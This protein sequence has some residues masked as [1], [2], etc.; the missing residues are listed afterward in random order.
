MAK[1][2][3]LDGVDDDLA[4]PSITIDYMEME[5]FIPEQPPPVSGPLPILTINYGV[6]M[7]YGLYYNQGNPVGT[8]FDLDSFKIDERCLIKTNFTEVATSASYSIFNIYSI[9]RTKGNIYSITLKLNG[10]IVAH[11][12]M[13]T[14]TVQDQSG[15]GRHATLTGGAWMDDGET[16]SEGEFVQY[17][18]VSLQSIFSDR[19]I[20]SGLKQRVFQQKS[21]PSSLRQSTFNIIDSTN[22]ITQTIYARL[23]GNNSSIQQIYKRNDSI[24]DTIQDIYVVRAINYDIMQQYFERAVL[25]VDYNL[26]LTICRYAE[27]HFDLRQMS[28]S[29]KRRYYAVR[30]QIFADVETSHDTSLR[31]YQNTRTDFATIQEI[32]NE[33][34]IR[35]ENF[36]MRIA[37]HNR[38]ISEYDVQQLMYETKQTYADLLQ[39]VSDLDLLTVDTK[40]T[41]IRRIANEQDLVQHIFTI[42]EIDFDMLTRLRDDLIDIISVIYLEAKRELEVRLSAEQKLDIA[43][44]AEVAST[45]HLKGGINMTMINQDFTMYSGDS[46]YL[47][48]SIANVENLNDLTIVWGLRKNRYRKSEILTKTGTVIDGMVQIKLEPEDTEGINGTFYHECEV[49]DL[50]GNVSTVFTGECTLKFSGV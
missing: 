50:Q 29:D 32:F 5:V 37:V 18:Y 19:S 26:A 25:T 12:D 9:I 42:R 48:F 31:I 44:R 49:T 6:G 22:D 27:K 20:S 35:I 34:V 43:L 2:L 23:E 1:Y 41:I 14:G 4:I 24:A 21:F 47:R 30:N 17:S 8:G 13:S 10:T 46:K 36:A 11:Y 16:P 28:T 33:S 38:S 3:Y 45:I 7:G 39:I 40:Q 15:N